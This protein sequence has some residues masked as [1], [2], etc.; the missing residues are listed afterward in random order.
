MVFWLSYKQSEIRFQAY[1]DSKVSFIKYIFSRFGWPRCE[2]QLNPATG[3][4]KPILYNG[5]RILFKSH[6]L[7]PIFWSFFY[8]NL[9]YMRRWKANRAQFLIMWWKEGH[10]LWG[11]TGKFLCLANNGIPLAKADERRGSWRIFEDLFSHVGG[12]LMA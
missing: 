5:L 7:K 4:I 8:F 2:G 6:F 12:R 3:S 10:R 1:F 9:H 11:R